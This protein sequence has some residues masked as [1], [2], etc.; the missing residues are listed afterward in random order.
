M[1]WVEEMKTAMKMMK[2]ACSKSNIF[3][4]C[5]KCPFGLYCDV[6]DDEG[7]RLPYEWKDEWINGND[8]YYQ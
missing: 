7:M 6:L 3:V 4:N 8:S 1:E 2:S 5:D